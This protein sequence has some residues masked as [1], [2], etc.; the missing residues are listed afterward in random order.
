MTV[1]KSPDKKQKDDALVFHCHEFEILKCVNFLNSIIINIIIIHII[2]FGKF[3]L[4]RLKL[5]P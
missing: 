1:R 5:L 2:L 4:L 3:T